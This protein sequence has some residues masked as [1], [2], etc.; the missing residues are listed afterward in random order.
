MKK[1]LILTVTAGNGH[2]SAANAVKEQCEKLGAE[3]KLVDLLHEFCDKKTFVWVQEKGYPFVCQYLVGIFNMFFRHY[4][5]AKPEKYFKSPVQKDLFG[6]Y[7]KLLKLIYDFQPDA[8][9]CSHY[10]PAIMITNLRKN[11]DVPAKTFAFVFDYVVCPFWESA[12]GIDFLLVPNEDFVEKLEQ[13]GFKKQQLL[14]FGLVVNQKFSHEL[15]KVTARS[16]LGLDKDRFTIFVMFGGGFWS[17]NYAIVKNLLRHLK[18]PNVQIVVA[19]G[20]DKKGKRKI[21]KLKVP[22]NIKLFNFGFCK[23]VDVI[24]SSADVLIGKAGGVS[25]TEAMNKKLPLLCCKKLPEQ[26]KVNVRMLVKN[27]IAKQY[28]NKKM[29]IR[30]VSELA[31]NPNILQERQE[32]I[33]KIRK[34]DATEKVCKM[35]MS[36]SADYENCSADFQ[37]VDKIVKKSLKKAGGGILSNPNRKN[38]QKTLEKLKICFKQFHRINDNNKLVFCEVVL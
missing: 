38:T 36:C 10:F 6:M 17:G 11:F 25:V 20:R 16:M 8:I 32:N 29:L 21:D 2:N 19:N 33:L 27:G 34:P 28:K 4:Q 31:E 12:T 7:G 35:M 14:P 13:K 30:F 26:E 18:V 9:F 22:Q 37:T 23:N 3:V 15:D 1:I 5:K 24:M